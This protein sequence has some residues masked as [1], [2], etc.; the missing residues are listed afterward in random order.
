RVDQVVARAAL[1]KAELL[2]GHPA[3][4]VLHGPEP[5]QEWDSRIERRKEQGA[6]TAPSPERH[7]C[8]VVL[9]GR[10]ARDA[11]ELGHVTER[12]IQIEPPPVVAADQRLFMAG[13]GAQYGAAVRADV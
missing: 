3:A 5:L 11:L 9:L 12:A 4:A 2:D 13:S 6:G 10:K 7:A 8:Q 1:I